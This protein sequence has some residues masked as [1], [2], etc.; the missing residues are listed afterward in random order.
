MVSGWDAMACRVS[1][2]KGWSGV[3]TCPVRR[4]DRQYNHTT[5]IIQKKVEGVGAGLNFGSLR[6]TTPHVLARAEFFPPIKRIQQMAGI[7]GRSG[8]ARK[9]AGA[10]VLG[11]E[12]P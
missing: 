10:A 6:P 8:G 11:L 5:L 9:N 7:K 2:R 4:L 1:E 3:K 12:G